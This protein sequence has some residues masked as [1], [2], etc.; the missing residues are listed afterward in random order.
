MKI[1]IQTVIAIAVAAILI[2]VAAL[3]GAGGLADGK[4][5]ALA[6]IS[7]Y[8]QNVYSQG[9]ESRYLAEDQKQTEAKHWVTPEEDAPQRQVYGWITGSPRRD[10]W[11]DEWRAHPEYAQN[12]GNLFRIDTGNSDDGASIV[13]LAAMSSPLAKLSW[14]TTA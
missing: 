2:A 8:V 6:K 13:W 11:P 5:D 14:P 12:Y 10:D 4:D 9:D 7:K 1:L 3:L